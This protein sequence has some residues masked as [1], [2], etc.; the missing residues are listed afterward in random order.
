MIV[1]RRNIR[2]HRIAYQIWGNCQK[3][4]WYRTS[5]EIADAVG[6]DPRTVRGIAQARGWN[7]R[8]KPETGSPRK[9]AEDLSVADQAAVKTVLGRP[10]DFAA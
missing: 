10:L 4:G 8:F 9:H 7:D 2:A 5:T 6:V 1:Q 3:H